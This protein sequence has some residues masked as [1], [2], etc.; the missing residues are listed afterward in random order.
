[1]RRCAEIALDLDRAKRDARVRRIDMQQ[2][3]EIFAGHHQDV[4]IA[5]GDHSRRDSWALLGE[6]AELSRISPCSM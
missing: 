1:M 3:E 6:D 5:Q 4:N 2:V